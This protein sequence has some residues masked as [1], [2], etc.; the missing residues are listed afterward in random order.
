MATKAEQMLQQ[1][2]EWNVDVA[3]LAE[4][5]T[6]WEHTAA[7]KVIN[8]ITQQFDKNTCWTTSSSK[9]QS[10]SLY[11]PVGTGTVVDRAWSGNII[12]RGSDWAGLGR[13]SYI[14]MNGKNGQRLTII[15]GYRCGNVQ[16]QNVG[17]FTAIF[18]QYSIMREKG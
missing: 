1:L 12:D 11:K 13:W 15:T 4:T 14:T 16:I 10:G 17:F 9:A 18:Q 2:F 5:C 7:K 8:R 3:C 6:A